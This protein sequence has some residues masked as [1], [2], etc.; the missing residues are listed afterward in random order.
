MNDDWVSGTLA[1]SYQF[2][3]SSLDWQSVDAKLQFD[4]RN[5]ALPH[6]AL[7]AGDSPLRIDRWDV[8][9]RLHEG[10][11]EIAKGKLVSPSGTYEVSGTASLGRDL[12]F[13]LTQ[14]ESVN[15]SGAAAYSIQGTLAEPRVAL[16]PAPQTQ[17]QL[18]P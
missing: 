15:A 9:A 1:G 11:I 3:S 8:Q 14:G 4:L 12:D 13:K 18:K 17:A 5:G 2:K 6:I 16:V 7:N 10:E